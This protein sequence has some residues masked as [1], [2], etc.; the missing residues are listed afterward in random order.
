MTPGM[1]FLIDAAG[2]V[3]VVLFLG[4]YAALQ[5]GL[6]RGTG[7]LYASLNLC[8]AS[9]VLLSLMSAFN[10][11]SAVIQVSWIIIS[12]VGILRTFFLT[13]AVRFTAEEAAL[14][15]AKFP[16]LPKI[17]GRRLMN[18]GSWNDA[19]AGT[20]LMTEGAPHGVLIYIASGRAHVHA[21]GAHVGTVEP[22]AFL[23]EMTVLEGTSATA[24]VTLE[25]QARFFR[26]SAAELHRLGRRDQDFKILLE[27]ALSRDVR[28]KLVATNARLRRYVDAGSRE[29]DPVS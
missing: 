5:T 28:L 11:S 17:A 27:N 4:A 1:E 22:G 14:L 18:A 23:G 15:N 25:T 9:L 21:N 20:V 19:P 3:G 16:K 6:I 7:Y 2:L 29:P 13:R 10:L 8:A 26:I 24:T 12:A